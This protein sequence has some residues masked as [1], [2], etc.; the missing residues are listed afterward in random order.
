[1]AARM[2]EDRLWASALPTAR[3]EGRRQSASPSRLETHPE[4]EVRAGTTVRL[5]THFDRFPVTA[6]LFAA[7][8][9]THHN[10]RNSRRV[11]A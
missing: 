3:P 11:R 6:P 5:S 2:G 1:M 8:P 7:R 9:D 10:M 4:T